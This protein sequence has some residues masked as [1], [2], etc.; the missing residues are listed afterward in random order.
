MSSMP[1]TNAYIC[2]IMGGKH[3]RQGRWPE[4]AYAGHRYEVA[5]WRRN[6]KKLRRMAAVEARAWR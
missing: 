1:L 5:C 2:S 3:S 6:G 4:T